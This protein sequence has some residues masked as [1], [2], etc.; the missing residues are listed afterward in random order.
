MDRVLV[1]SQCRQLAKA[2][3]TGIDYVEIAH[4]AEFQTVFAESL[5]FS[6]SARWA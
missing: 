5:M 6:E 4:E 2:I 1:S 3:A